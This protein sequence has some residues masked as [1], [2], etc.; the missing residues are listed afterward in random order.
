MDVQQG[1]LNPFFR[2]QIGGGER[3]RRCHPGRNQQHAAAWESPNEFENQIMVVRS[4]D[5][6]VH[7]SN[8]VHVADLEDGGLESISFTDY[9]SNVDGRAT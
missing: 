9:P 3:A 2:Q 4:T 6:G 5:G 7:W 1:A 8:P